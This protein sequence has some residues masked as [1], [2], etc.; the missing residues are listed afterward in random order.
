MHQIQSIQK[1]Y[2]FVLW[3]YL[4]WTVIYCCLYI[5]IENCRMR[6]LF[7]KI[8]KKEYFKH[9]S[10]ERW[11]EKIPKQIQVLCTLSTLYPSPT[12][13]FSPSTHLQLL[14]FTSSLHFD[15][16]FKNYDNFAKDDGKKNFTQYCVK[17]AHMS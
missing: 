14:S 1:I 11:H 8:Q 9:K 3:F 4:T 12:H 10:K 6:L 15:F 13:C 7:W 5:Q 2:Q 17:Y 16:V